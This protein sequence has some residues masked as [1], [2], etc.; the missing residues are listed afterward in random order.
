MSPT[1]AAQYRWAAELAP[2]KHFRIISWVFGWITFWGWQLTTAS[3]AYLGATI[4]QSL[5]VL[6]YPEY[7]E[8]YQ[9]WHETLIYWCIIL[10]GVIVNVG[11]ARWLPKLEGFLFILAYSRLLRGLDPSRVPWTSDRCQI[12]VHFN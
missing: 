9:V 5:A 12:F 6:N 4:I 11:F 8:K 7:L 2:K 10:I 3:P 1:S